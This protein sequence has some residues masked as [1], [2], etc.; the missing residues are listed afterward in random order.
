[1]L[2]IFFVSKYILR[3]NYEQIA[4][5][6]Y[7]AAMYNK[8]AHFVFVSIAIETNEFQGHTPGQTS[9]TCHL[10]ITVIQKRHE[11]GISEY[12]QAENM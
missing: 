10:V 11:R 3:W 1:M 2:C 9:L 8:G 5:I 4:A 7:F 12:H 6:E